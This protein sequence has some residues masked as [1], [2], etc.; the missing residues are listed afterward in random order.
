MTEYKLIGHGVYSFAEAQRLTKVP[1]STIRRWTRG[2]KFS[3]GTTEYFSP[4][5]IGAE[6]ADGDTV[7]Q[8]V[9]LMEVRVL[10]QFRSAG[11]SWRT[12]RMAVDRAR[13]ITGQSHPF[14]LRNFVTDGRSILMRIDDETLL[15]IVSN[16]QEFE[17]LVGPFLED[18]DYEDQ[19]DPK[20]WWPLGHN[21]QVVID[22][23]RNFGTPISANRGVPTRILYSQY[24]IEKDFEPVAWWH[25]VSRQEVEDAVEFEIRL[26]A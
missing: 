4:P 11:V 22:P 20:R 3:H 18:I 10:D 26:A 23:Q 8:F 19:D 13:E 7:L 15:D 5:V 24:L 1:S 25:D 17:K 9:D 2:Y 14:S 6:G 16:Q 21:R 12:M